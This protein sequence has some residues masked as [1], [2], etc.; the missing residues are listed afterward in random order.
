MV[1]SHDVNITL[2]HLYR[3]YD[4]FFYMLQ[5]LQVQN[6]QSTHVTTSFSNW[7]SHS[8]HLSAPVG[9]RAH[10]RCLTCSKTDK[11]SC[12][13]YLFF[14]P[15]FKAVSCIVIFMLSSCHTGI[16][17]N[18]TRNRVHLHMGLDEVGIRI[19]L[20][21][22]TNLDNKFGKDGH[23]SNSTLCSTQPTAAWGPYSS[24][25]SMNQSIKL[26]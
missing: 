24:G 5:N 1:T 19:N 20:H 2:Y 18:I 26:L 8:H 6:L 15:I 7:F 14:K 4:S 10:H 23:S 21:E 3:N 22:D 9:S 11:S 13:W 16:G 17:V 25:Q 12:L